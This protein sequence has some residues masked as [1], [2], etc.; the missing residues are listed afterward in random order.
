MRKDLFYKD[1]YPIEK[2][3]SNQGEPVLFLEKH[4]EKCEW[5]GGELINLFDFNLTNPL[6]KFINFNAK[7]YRMK[8]IKSALNVMNI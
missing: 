7:K 1:C 6:L 8:N 4:S 3:D 5:C 2:T